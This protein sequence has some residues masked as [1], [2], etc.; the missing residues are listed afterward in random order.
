MTNENDK[1]AASESPAS[2]VTLHGDRTLEVPLQYPAE[3]EG[4]V[5]DKVV[6]RRPTRAEVQTFVEGG[7]LPIYDVPEVVFEN[8]D[9]DDYEKV[10]EVM[11]DFLPLSLQTALALAQE[12]GG[13]TSQ[14]SQASSEA[15][16]SNTNE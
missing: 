8:L 7:K 4:V 9:P 14:P 11:L 6:V 13:D 1:P 2:V 10:N 16:S 3:F 12:N 15:G 5:Y